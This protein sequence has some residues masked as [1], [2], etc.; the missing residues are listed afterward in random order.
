MLVVVTIVAMFWFPD[1][2]GGTDGHHEA[3]TARFDAKTGNSGTID[4]HPMMGDA[5]VAYVDRIIDRQLTKVRGILAFDGLIL[6]FLG[7]ISHGIGTLDVV[8]HHQPPIL[9]LIGLLAISSGICLAQF[10]SRWGY[11]ADFLTFSRE[12][13]ATLG[14][15]RRRSIWIERTVRLSLLALGGIVVLLVATLA[16]I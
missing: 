6:A 16:G 12:I 15:A 4:D 14:L 7:L 2:P 3:L 10:R 8:A 1:I 9:L 5:A 13:A 11:V